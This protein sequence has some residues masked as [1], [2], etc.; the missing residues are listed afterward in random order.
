MISR[1]Y[2]WSLSNVIWLM[3]IAV[4]LWAL[5]GYATRKNKKAEKYWRYIN[6]ALCISSCFLI[7]KMTLLGR[8]VGER[9]LILMPFYTFTTM[10]YNNEALRTLLM[11]V[12]L[13][14]PLGL[15]LPYVKKEKKSHKW[16]H[17]I[18]LGCVLSIGVELLQY[19]FALGQAE[20]D[21]VICNTLGCALGVTADMMAE[22]A[23]LVKKNEI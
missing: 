11:N 18:L 15:T 20:M 17:C 21:D 14:L 5:I 3:M 2:C 8:T 10:S 6:M 19:C 12:I 7:I 23:S 13:F 1:F 22:M 16:I 4:I 9:T